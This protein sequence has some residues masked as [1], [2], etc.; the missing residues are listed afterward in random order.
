M[1]FLADNKDVHLISS[2]SL[3]RYI[4]PIPFC[5]ILLIP[6]HRERASLRI[7]VR[8]RST[9]SLHTMLTSGFHSRCTNTFISAFNISFQHSFIL[10]LIRHRDHGND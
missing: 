9:A 8:R 5:C 2:Y 7:V 3:Y 1:L 4:I 6:L 10:A